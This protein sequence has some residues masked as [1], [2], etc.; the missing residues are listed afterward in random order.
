MATNLAETDVHFDA[1]TIATIDDCDPC[2][3]RDGGRC[4]H[5]E[6]EG[7]ALRTNGGDPPPW[8]RL[9]TGPLVI[10]LREETAHAR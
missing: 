1:A 9:R 4:Y 10:R 6:T 8:C 3:L 5:P 7:W 2:P